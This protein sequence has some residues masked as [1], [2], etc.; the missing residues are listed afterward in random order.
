VVT[1]DAI[2]DAKFDPKAG[3]PAILQV[4][5]RRGTV[6]FQKITDADVVTP[7]FALRTQAVKEF[8]VMV[9]GVY[10]VSSAFAFISA[11]SLLF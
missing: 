7:S 9:G 1:A 10:L 11:A 2:F 3:T 8:N 5:E 4:P 6:Y